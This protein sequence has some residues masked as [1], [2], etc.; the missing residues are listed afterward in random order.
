MSGSGAKNPGH[1]G[2]TPDEVVAPM[3][4]DDL[5]PDARLVATRS[6]TIAAPPEEVF[7]WLRQMGFGRAGWYSWDIL[8]NLGRRS[9]TEIHPEWQNLEPGDPVPGGP[10]DFTAAVVE[11]PRALVLMI[12]SSSH[13]TRRL[14]FTLAYDLRDHP[15]GTR[16]V[17]RVRARIDVPGGPLMERFIL[18]PG[19][20]FMLR[21]QL[22]QLSRRAAPR[23][24]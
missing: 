7:P 16:L 2:A 15:A 21:R 6:I 1:W 10:I 13:A 14:N 24:G 19:D 18:G 5:C 4:G 9:A 20:G 11:P 8:D 17:T 22:R 3:V 12:G 23:L